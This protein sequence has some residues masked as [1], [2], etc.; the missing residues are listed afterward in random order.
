MRVW[1]ALAAWLAAFPAL[2]SDIILQSTTSTQNSGLLDFILPQFTRET[3]INVRVVAVGTGQAIKNAMNGDGDILLVHARTLEDKFIDDGW[4]IAR[5]EVMYNDF[6]II[7]PTDDPA[8]VADA[9]D[10]TTAFTRVAA[11]P[12]TFV[13]RGDD[14]G[15]YVKEYEL[16]GRAGIDPRPESGGWYK[17]TGAGMGTTLNIAVELNAYTLTDRATWISFGNKRDHTILFQG[18][19]ALFNPYGLVEINPERHPFINATDAHRLV[20]WMTGPKGQKAIADYKL[21]G[22]QLFFPVAT[23]Q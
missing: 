10:A 8:D 15:T 3:G 21:D 11:M 4:G 5:H 20:E 9:P 23:G 13:S 16:W 17:E 7:G 1:L 14:S 12:A 2:A 19:P 22:Q 18:D 6:V